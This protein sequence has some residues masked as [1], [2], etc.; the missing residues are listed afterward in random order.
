MDYVVAT[1]EGVG[2]SGPLETEMIQLQPSGHFYPERP[3][4]GNIRSVVEYEPKKPNKWSNESALLFPFFEGMDRSE[5]TN[6]THHI[7]S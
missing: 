3:Y 1:I 7:I 2:R 5:Y 6:H 4:A